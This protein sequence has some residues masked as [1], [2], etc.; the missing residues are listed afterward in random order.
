MNKMS[1]L[2]GMQGPIK[3][4]AAV[5]G[6]AYQEIYQLPLRCEFMFNLEC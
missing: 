3:I 5:N 6:F 2:T 1:E 4:P